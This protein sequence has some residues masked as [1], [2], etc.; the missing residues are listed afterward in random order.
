MNDLGETPTRIRAVPGNMYVGDLT[1][2]DVIDRLW[3]V[4]QDRAL[5]NGTHYAYIRAAIELIERL[6]HA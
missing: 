1:A 3:L 5:D 2:Q 4:A 6:R